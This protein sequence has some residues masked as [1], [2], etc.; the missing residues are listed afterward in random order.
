MENNGQIPPAPVEAPMR[1]LIVETDGN[2][3]K[4]V[5]NEMTGLLELKAVLTEML[6][7]LR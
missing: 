1:Q 2:Q 6:T 5:K 7:Q 3:I 4:I